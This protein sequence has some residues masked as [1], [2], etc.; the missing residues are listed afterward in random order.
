MSVGVETFTASRLTL[1]RE[2]RGLTQRKLSQLV[3]VSDRMIKAYESGEKNPTA[4]TLSVIARELA[5]PIAF[6]QAP[7]MELFE[8]EAASF[9]AL[10]KAS[11]ALRSR[12]VAAGTIALAFHRYLAERFELPKAD[13]PDLRTSTPSKAAEALRH[14]WCLG[15]KPISN[16]VHLLELHGVVVFSLSEDCESIDAFSIWH[17]GTPYI[18]L[19]NRKTAERGIFD[20]AHEL[21]HLV[22]HRH[23]TPRGRDGEV[24]ADQF[25]AS[26]LMPESA[27]RASAPWMVTIGTLSAMK[28]TWKVSV[29]ALGYRLH[30]L[31]LVSEY[32]YRHFNIELSRRGRRNEPSPLARETSA[33]LR[34]TLAALAE[35]GIKLRDIAHELCL[36]LKELQALVFGL[37]VVEGDGGSSTPGRG[38][39]R[40]VT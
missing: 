17:D 37:G 5:F 8:L 24:Q 2:R 14:Q 38:L 21:G 32:H 10:S 33:I 26:L 19:N 40:V 30:E 29:A 7:S 13:L 16:L 1:A 31:G 34:K 12:T 23:G 18:F 20:A 11:S 22:L 39:L 9:R 3:G 36:P 25:A 6:F 28:K 27:M 15:Q 35:E 4:D